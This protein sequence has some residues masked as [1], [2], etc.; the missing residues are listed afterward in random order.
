MDG[1]AE[2]LL[3]MFLAF[4]CLKAER[5]LFLKGK[6]VFYCKFFYHYVLFLYSIRGLFFIKVFLSIPRL[7]DSISDILSFSVNHSVLYCHKIDYNSR[8]SFYGQALTGSLDGK[9]NTNEG[10]YRRLL[11][12][13][14]LTEK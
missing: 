5:H 3:Q 12:Q 10:S 4:V 8:L 14:Y 11:K 2:L 13:K 9:E 1:L 6:E 7:Y